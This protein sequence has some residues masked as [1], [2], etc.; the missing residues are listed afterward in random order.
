MFPVKHG[1]RKTVAPVGAT[2]E[3]LF[4]ALLPVFSQQRVVFEDTPS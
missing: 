3:K 2:S 1:L 4:C